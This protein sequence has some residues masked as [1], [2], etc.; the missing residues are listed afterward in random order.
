MTRHNDTIL[1]KI[2][3]TFGQLDFHFFLSFR[4]FWTRDLFSFLRR[5]NN[6]QGHHLIGR[7]GIRHIDAVSLG[8]CN[9]GFFFGKAFLTIVLFG[10]GNKVRSTCAI[11]TTTVTSQSNGHDGIF[12]FYRG[13]GGRGGR[14]F[15]FFRGCLFFFGCCFF[16][17]FFLVFFFFFWVCDS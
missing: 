6:N 8:L 12:L 10:G 4:R 16:F 13:R 1:A 15:L 17:F 7:G 14:F 3:C 5:R 9:C 11:N 2:T